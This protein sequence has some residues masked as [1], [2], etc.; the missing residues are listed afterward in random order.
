MPTLMRFSYLLLAALSVVSFSS[1]AQPAPKAPANRSV[2]WQISGKQL[3]KP[4]YVFG[5]MH[6]VCAGDLTVS[7]AV[8]RAMAKAGQ[9]TM[10]LDMDNPT[11]QEQMRAHLTL[12]AGQTLAACISQQ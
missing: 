10:E 7:R 8:R 11:M 1:W 5:T 6:L 2:L 3:A 9:I 4:S 12:P